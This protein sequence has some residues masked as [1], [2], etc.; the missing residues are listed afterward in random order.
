MKKKFLLIATGF[1]LSVSCFGAA[2]KASQV[3]ADTAIPNTADLWALR[4]GSATFNNTNDGIYMTT[5]YEVC[6]AYL[7][8]KVCIDGLEFI[9][10]APDVSAYSCFYPVFTYGS[11]DYATL[12]MK[13]AIYPHTTSSPEDIT[14][15]FFTTQS[16]PSTSSVNPKNYMEPSTDAKKGFEDGLTLKMHSGTDVGIGMRFNVVSK[17]WVK[18]ILFDYNPGSIISTCGNYELDSATGIGS[19]YTYVQAKEF[20]MDQN[21]YATMR[22][23]AGEL[24]DVYVERLKDTRIEHT[25]TTNIKSGKGTIDEHRYY[26]GYT[27]DV[28]GKPNTGYQIKETKIYKT[29]DPSTTVEVKDGKFVMPAFDITIDT[30]FEALKY[31]V[32]VSSAGNG[33]ITGPGQTGTDTAL[34]FVTTPDEDYKLKG[35]YLKTDYITYDFPKMDPSEIVS[36]FHSLDLDGDGK[37]FFVGTTGGVVVGYVS[38]S[39]DPNTNEGLTPDNLLVSPSIS[40]PEDHL[41]KCEIVY[42]VSPASSSYFEENFD[43]LIFDKN[44]DEIVASMDE[45][46]T[47]EDYAIQVHKNEELKANTNRQE[48][49]FELDD[50]ISGDIYVTFRHWN[51]VDVYALIIRDFCIRTYL[52]F[53]PTGMVMPAHD[54]DVKAAFEIDYSSLFTKYKNQLKEQLDALGADH[55]DVLKNA[56][57]ALDALTYDDTKTLDENKALADN[58]IVDVKKNLDKATYNDYIDDLCKTRHF[59]EKQKQELKAIGYDESKSLQENLDVINEKAA[60]MKSGS[61]LGVG[62]IIGIVLGSI[63]LLLAGAYFA[64]GFLVYKKGKLKGKFFDT[65]YK[66]IKKEE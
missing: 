46:K 1:L 54:I 30:Y 53:D 65:I 47:I 59:S 58:A 40:L 25:A 4:V 55:G 38:Y 60:G 42:G 21:G 44:P 23:H 16:S 7:K 27:Y 64:V 62:G 37:K 26:E 22:V 29:G 41:G 61:P 49:S 13:I 18:V 3:Y 56:K 45:G 20:N 31:N 14:E 12:D 63:V 39:Y 52:P 43:V 8:D 35:L 6:E 5:T 2:K 34:E 57:A 28:P 19:C 32:N 33:T 36:N 10:H 66:W 15:V 17:D 9:I 24:S 48:Y 11:G 51:T 50:S